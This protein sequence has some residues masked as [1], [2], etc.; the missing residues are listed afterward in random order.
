MQSVAQS[1]LI[2]RL[3]D[4]GFLLGLTATLTLIP[5][6]LFGIYGGW[7]ADRYSRRNLLLVAHTLAMLQAFT[8]GVLTIGGWVAP[9]HILLLAL[10][11]GIVQAVETPVRQS[12]IFQLVTRDNLPNAIAL[13]SSMFH[14]ARF[15]GPAIAGV[16]V[17]WIGEGPVF[18]INGFTFVAVLVSLFSLQLPRPTEVA[19]Q[20]EGLIGIWSGLHYAWNHKLIRTALAMVA[21]VSLLGGSAVVLM[22]IFVVDVFNHGPDS[23]GLLMGMLGSGSLI[24]ALMLASKRDYQ[25]LE[26]RVAISGVAV[27][28]GLFIFA[29][30]DL[31]WF[32]LCVLIV[33]GF[34][35]TT[36][37]ATSNALIQLTVPDHLRGRVMALFAVCLHGMVSI[38]QLVLGSVA[39]V[40]GAPAT[41]GFSGAV[42][43]VLALFLAVMLFK[44]KQ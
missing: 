20:K 19:E 5:S 16:L 36:V 11:L 2:Y 12:F 4:S 22:P 6:L 42:L 29:V 43:F 38:G 7:L 9:W 3:T 1:W 24:G 17:T 18:V 33:I 32:A 25:L 8:L 34:A 23:L 13:S 10:A 28:I 37:F 26:R 35:S 15:I 14:V 39:D 30:N 31:Y 40:V 21:T 27:G 44:I 41:A